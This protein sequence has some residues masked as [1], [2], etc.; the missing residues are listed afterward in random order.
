MVCRAISNWTVFQVMASDGDRGVFGEITYSLISGDF[1]DFYINTTAAGQYCTYSIVDDEVSFCG[2]QVELCTLVGA[3]TM[4][5]GRPT[6][7]LSRPQTHQR[8]GWRQGQ[9]YC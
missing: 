4:R 7:S 3:W 8:K 2:T 6:L 1:D 5:Q 9:E